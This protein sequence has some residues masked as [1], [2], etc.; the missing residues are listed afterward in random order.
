MRQGTE[1]LYGIVIAASIIL[2]AAAW[3]VQVFVRPPAWRTSST[4]IRDMRRFSEGV[5]VLKDCARLAGELVAIDPTSRAARVELLRAR[6]DYQKALAHECGVSLVKAGHSIAPLADLAQLL[7]EAA[8]LVD[9]ALLGSPDGVVSAEMI[10]SSSVSETDPDRVGVLP[11]VRRLIEIRS[12]QILARAEALAQGTEQQVLGSHLYVARFG[13]IE[14]RIWLVSLCSATVVLAL[15]ASTAA[16]LRLRTPPATMIERAVLAAARRDARE[17][18]EMCY[19]RIDSMLALA[20]RLT[21]EA[22][23]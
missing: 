2:L 3:A 18:I 1:R 21:R 7:M 5:R 6:G 9:S 17:A 16:V 22:G 11:G 4:M 8:E 12:S 19:A 15:L 10:A 23:T 13:G 14:A 20:D